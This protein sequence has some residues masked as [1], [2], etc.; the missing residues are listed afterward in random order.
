M[1][2][3][4]KL[5]S[6]IISA[7]PKFPNNRETKDKLNAMGL[8]T[9]L[10]HYLSWMSRYISIKPRRV[11]IEPTAVN[12]SRWI[13]LKPAIDFLLDKVRRGANLTPHLSI[14][15]RSRGYTPTASISSSSGNRWADKDFLLNTCGYHHLHLGTELSE[16]NEHVNRTK[17]VIFVKVNRDEFIVIGFF[18]HSVFQQNS[19]E[20]SPERNRLLEIFHA[21]STQGV[22]PGS[23]VISSLIASSGHPIHVLSIAQ[24][25][26]RLIGEIDPKLDDQQF[27]QN[28]YRINDS[29]IP[30]KPQWE[31]ELNFSALY[32]WDKKSDLRLMVHPG[33]N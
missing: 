11:K 27:I 16:N 13:I 17:D 24:E 23:V 6:E 32:I 1:K 4:T 26:S 14:Q 25:Y 21:Y 20:M 28:Q 8:P 31:W 29:E 9:L 5:R 3:V 30:D 33:F 18:N 10:L 12:D 15:S 7:I 19:E 2:R 22:S